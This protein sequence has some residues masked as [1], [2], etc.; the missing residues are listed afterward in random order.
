MYLTALP[1]FNEVAHVANVLEEVLELPL[2]A[3]WRKLFQRRLDAGKVED[4]K[5]RMQR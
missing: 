4:W 2:T 3:S 1:V 5:S